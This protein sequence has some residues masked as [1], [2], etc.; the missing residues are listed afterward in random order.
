MKDK[1]ETFERIIKR[2]LNEWPK[3]KWPKKVWPIKLRNFQWTTKEIL[4]EGPTKK[5]VC[6]DDQRMSKWMTD[7]LKESLNTTYG[8]ISD[9]LHEWMT[10]RIQVQL[11]AWMKDQLKK[12]V[13]LN[14]QRKSEWMAERL[15]KLKVL[16][17]T[18]NSLTKWPTNRESDRP[19]K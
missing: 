2:S 12:N 14:D 1:R 16:W 11:K 10:E 19:K 8:T 18:K 4:I 17:I 13:Y 3:C 7:K 9:S 5:N 6:M 15:K